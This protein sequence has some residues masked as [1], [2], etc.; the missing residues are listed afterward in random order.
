MLKIINLNDL[1]NIDFRTRQGK[2]IL[3][4][5]KVRDKK[6]L[7]ELIKKKSKEYN[8]SDKK[9]DMDKNKKK[10]D[11]NKT[12]K[13]LHREKN[14]LVKKVVFIQRKIRKYLETE[15]KI[16][17]PARFNL[18][19]SVNDTDFISLQPLSKIEKFKFFSYYDNNDK[20][21]LIYSFDIFSLKKIFEK[22]Q[23]INPYNQRLFNND[24]IDLV[25]KRVQQVSLRYEKENNLNSCHYISIDKIDLNKYPKRS[26]PDNKLSIVEMLSR[27]D[28]DYSLDNYNLKRRTTE[29]FLKI[30]K[31]DFVTNINWFNQ[32]NLQQYKN[33]YIYLKDLWS[34]RCQLSIEGKKKIVSN[35]VI[36]NIPIYKI[37]Q[38]NNLALVKTI[39][40]DQIEKLITQGQTKND[41]VLGVIYILTS[42]TSV[43]QDAANSYPW[44]VQD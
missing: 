2:D 28:L 3:L 19:L 5:Y 6:R 34:Y 13:S 33:F 36:C 35:G 15:K 32:L 18:S 43:C 17:G 16:Y 12:K 29:L 23:F 8:I 20:N 31:L 9:E 22:N 4:R 21:N 10:E 42:F 30:D 7:I 11:M 1:K 39:I 26:K 24:V 37:N 27:Q 14:T 25:N 44:L 41:K 40:L 38:L